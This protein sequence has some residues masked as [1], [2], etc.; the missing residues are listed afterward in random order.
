M[1]RV[2]GQLLLINVVAYVFTR[3]NPVLMSELWLVP[4]QVLTRPWTLITYQFLHG[5][6]SHIFFNMLALFFFGPKLESLLGS[7]SF[8][9]LYLLAGIVGALVHILWT[10]PTMS[11]GTLYIPMV[12]A[13]A[14]VYG[15]LFGY[16]RYWPRDRVMIWFVIPVQVRFLVIGFTL[17]SLWLGLGGVGGGVAHFA[18]LGGF[19]GGWLYLRWRATRSAAAQ[20]RKKAESPGVRMGERELNV[21]WGRIEPTALHPVNRAEY[22]RIADKLKAAGWS[23]LTDRERTFVERFGGGFG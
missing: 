19:L 21:K 15:V 7:K 3:T 6:V 1:T 16:A 23:A 18:H 12:G 20:F 11:Q 22:E 14:A 9:R 2:V 13:S 8:L 5:G 4:A 10:V 17:L